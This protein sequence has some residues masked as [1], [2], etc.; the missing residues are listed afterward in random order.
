ME[1]LSMMYTKLLLSNEMNIEALGNEEFLSD[2][3]NIR[4]GI[5]IPSMIR[6]LVVSLLKKIGQKRSAVYDEYMGSKDTVS[7]NK[8]VMEKIRLQEKFEEIFR[9]HNLDAIIS[10]IFSTPPCRHN[11]F[12]KTGYG[13]M[14]TAVFNIV[15]H[16]CVTIPRVHIIEKA[17]TNLNEYK[18][19]KYGEDPITKAMRASLEGSEGL[20]IGVQVS[21]LTYQ[22]E[23][24]LGV[25]KNIDQTLRQKGV[26]KDIEF[27]KL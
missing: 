17:D 15:D 19:R 18:D 9:K 26:I 27:Q 1:K 20:P 24:C 4:L 12:K 25:S 21:T 22:D 11:E 6:P 10:P 2:Y 16:P 8:M 3:Q 13:V 23:K 5:K 14:Y 7:Y